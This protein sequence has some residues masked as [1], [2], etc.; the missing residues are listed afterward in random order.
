MDSTPTTFFG[1]VAYLLNEFWPRFL[2]GTVNTLE[3]ALVGTVL[4]CALGF[5]VGI[6]QSIKVDSHASSVSR[7]LVGLLKAIVAIYVEIFRGTPMMVQAMVI[8]YGSAEMYGLD[9]NTF[10]AGILVLTLNT[11]AYMAESV[12]GA[13][14]A[15]TPASWRGL[16][17]RVYHFQA[18]TRVVIP[19]A[20]RTSSRR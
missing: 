18:M 11:G 14:T 15:S 7:A 19:Q 3:I 9:M 4:G 6:V 8:Y 16:R 10:F 17:H 13:I 20:F 5:V 2:A 12:R 1:W